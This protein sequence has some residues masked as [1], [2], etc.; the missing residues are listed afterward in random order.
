MRPL[1]CA[2]VRSRT[3]LHLIQLP[4]IACDFRT[5]L[6]LSHALAQSVKISVVSTRIIT[7]HLVRVFWMIGFTVWA[8]YRF[9][10]WRNKRYSWNNQWNRESG[11]ATERY[12][13][14]TVAC[15]S[16]KKLIISLFR[17][18]ATNWRA[19]FVTDKYQPCRVRPRFTGK[20]S[21]SVW[22][23]DT[24]SWVFDTRNSSGFV[25]GLV[26]TCQ[27]GLTHQ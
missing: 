13:F 19:V 26:R 15:A 3:R 25:L 23:F 4:L 27:V 2:Y 7:F 16:V 11:Y 24:C 20:N 17:D 1:C 8:T 18:H 10:Y 14:F 9:H 6:A 5:K 12:V 21:E 22:H